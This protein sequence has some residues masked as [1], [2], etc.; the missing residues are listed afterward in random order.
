METKLNQ[1]DD[2]N[3]KR[4]KNWKKLK[5]KQARDVRWLASTEGELNLEKCSLEHR[6]R[7]IYASFSNRDT[8]FT[9]LGE[10]WTGV[11]IN[12][13]LIR[14]KQQ[15]LCG[16]GGAWGENA[17][18]KQ[19]P[20]PS[21]AV[22]ATCHIWAGPASAH[23]ITFSPYVFWL[24]SEPT[25]WSIPQIACMWM[26]ARMHAWVC[27]ATRLWDFTMI[28]TSRESS[29]PSLLEKMEG[30][31]G[32]ERVRDRRNFE[33]DERWGKCDQQGDQCLGDRALAS[34]TDP[35]PSLSLSFLSLEDNKDGW[36]RCCA[37]RHYSPWL[38]SHLHHHLSLS[39]KPT[40][41]APRS[42]SALITSPPIHHGIDVSDRQCSIH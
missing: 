26:S 38:Q 31:E 33:R 3:S 27:T 4:G 8:V 32:N 1:K 7:N 11:S 40:P 15:P 29:P 19:Q 16:F 35:Q 17:N 39:S 5:P 13:A 30:K 18:S 9:K 10:M 14:K 37:I 42:N 41:H 24:W 36:H 2:L 20:P 34:L 22:M 12:K 21:S 28:N 25:A 6:N 23:P